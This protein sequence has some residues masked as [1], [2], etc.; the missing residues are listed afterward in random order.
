M[1]NISAF[2]VSG[3]FAVTL[4]AAQ[5][6]V[7]AFRQEG[8]ASW[9]GMEFEGRPT[10]SGELFDPSQFTAAHPD[11]PF[12]TM[13]VVTNAVN[14]E[15]VMVRV[16]D[17][18]PFVKS[19]IID[20]SKAAAEKLNM[21]ETGTAQ[22]I[23]ELAPR[24]A[25]TAA[26][27]AGT[28]LPA[29]ES[30]AAGPDVQA[31]TAAAPAPA[32]SPAQPSQQQHPAT[33]AAPPPYTPQ[34][35]SVV[36]SPPVPPATRDTAAAVPQTVRQTVPQAGRPPVPPPAASFQPIPTTARPPVSSPSTSAQ[37]SR[38]VAG[39]APSASAAP[40]ARSYPSYASADII[41]GPVVNGRYYRMQIGSYKVAKNAVEV[42]D[43]LSAASLNPQWEPFG[44]LYRIVLSN[45][46]AEDVNSTAARLGSAGF[47]EVI[48]R[49]ER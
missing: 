30:Y 45:V 48:V 49:E 38:P 24:N 1:K 4:C 36:Q 25:T 5:T 8:I 9:Y 37:P 41:G 40:S 32:A 19:R 22:V 44:N 3:L 13:L 27:D 47:K 34:Q 20:V 35:P 46:R 7:S 14:G 42:F 10:A 17:R 33:A 11:L 2:F 31:Q 39:S 12:G 43:R 23:I 26:V 16:N 18:G 6:P 15:K 28:A 21:L 29:S